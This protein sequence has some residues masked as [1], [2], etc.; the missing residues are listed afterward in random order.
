MAIGT[1]TTLFE[2]QEGTQKRSYYRK[3][4]L[5]FLHIFTQKSI[6]KIY[7]QFVLHFVSSDCKYGLSEPPGVQ[8]SSF[9]HA[10]RWGNLK[11]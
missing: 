7:I 2:L 6:F 4:I 11:Y 8:S 1:Y 10:S 3:K 9:V 5:R